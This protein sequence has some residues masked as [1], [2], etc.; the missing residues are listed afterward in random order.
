MS[1]TTDEAR[2][3]E[4][5]DFTCRVNPFRTCTDVLF[6]AEAAASVATA[7]ALRNLLQALQDHSRD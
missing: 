7:F 6:A 3:T 1:D 4:G 5:P 2:D